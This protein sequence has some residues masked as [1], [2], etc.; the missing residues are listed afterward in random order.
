MKGSDLI[1]V[2]NGGESVEVTRKAYDAHY[3]TNGYTIVGNS[4]PV[5]TKAELKAM[6]DDAGVEYPKSANLADL[7]ALA[8][9][10]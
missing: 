7:V 6:L 3:A 2:T 5:P 8:A 4:D 9:T 1:V 10:I